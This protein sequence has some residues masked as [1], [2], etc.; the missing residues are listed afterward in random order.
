M[1]SRG[2]T[3]DIDLSHHPVRYISVVLEIP[4]SPQLLMIMPC[5]SPAV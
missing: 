3:D 1:L 4:Q 5:T 2:F